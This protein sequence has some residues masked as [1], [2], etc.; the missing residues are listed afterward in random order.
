M[1]LLVCI[2]D[3]S[4]Y[5]ENLMQRAFPIVHEFLQQAMTSAFAQKLQETVVAVDMSNCL[6][7]P[8]FLKETTFMDPRKYRQAPHHRRAIWG[9]TQAVTDSIST[10]W[11]D[12]ISKLSL[13]PLGVSEKQLKNLS[14]AHFD[15]MWL[16]FDT[17][18][19]AL[20]GQ[21]DRPGEAGTVAKHFGLFNPADPGR[22]TLAKSLVK[23]PNPVRPKQ[24]QVECTSVPV[25]PLAVPLN[26][27]QNATER[28]KSGHSYISETQELRNKGK[29]KTRKA[30]E[31]GHA[32]AIPPPARNL[33]ED[34]E[35]AINFPDALPTEFKL[36]KKVMK[37]CFCL[38][39]QILLSNFNQGLPPNP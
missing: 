20:S 31:T 39:S 15:E 3:T 1:S 16:T 33:F 19:W 36:G 26:P 24:V 29:V 30:P 12:V 10:S 17:T 7:H 14:L 5:I 4:F 22:P 37:V 18:F 35:D 38:S 21:L 25:A 13:F 9:Y 11:V 28:A 23:H 27:E 8:E 2:P 34:E 32:E 6:K